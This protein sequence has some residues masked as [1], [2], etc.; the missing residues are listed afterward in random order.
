MR[1]G[2]RQAESA[3]GAGPARPA[4]PARPGPGQDRLPP[5]FGRQCERPEWWLCRV[6]AE[7]AADQR[8]DPQMESAISRLSLEPSVSSVR[9]HVDTPIV[10]RDDDT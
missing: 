6:R 5:A 4:R 3:A 7:L 2:C 9:W 8:D 1:S 10:E